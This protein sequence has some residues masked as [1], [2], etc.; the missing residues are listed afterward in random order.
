M[1]P[2][3]RGGDHVFHLFVIRTPERDRLREHLARCGIQTGLHYPVPLHRQ[4]C[5]AGFDMDRDSF[6]VADAFARE[7]LSLPL[8]AGMTEAQQDRVVAA[9]RDFFEHGA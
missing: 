2:A 4:P 5:L 1:L 9:M 8:F 6:P 7:G 3:T